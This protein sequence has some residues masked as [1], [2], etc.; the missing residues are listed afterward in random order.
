MIVLGKQ[1]GMR[2]NHAREEKRAYQRA[3]RAITHAR[4]SLNQS[5]SSGPF[6]YRRGDSH[7][8][9][10]NIPTGSAIR[11]GIGTCGGVADNTI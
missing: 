3:I 2:T 8:P 7:M 1:G 6:Q 9:Q 10:Y 5:G 4:P 11:L